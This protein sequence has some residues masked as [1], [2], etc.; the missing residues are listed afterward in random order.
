MMRNTSHKLIACLTLL[1]AGLTAQNQGGQPG[2]PG[3]AQPA[4][5]Q[6]AGAQP[7]P[8]QAGPAPAGAPATASNPA[9]A[10]PKTV[11]GPVAPFRRSQRGYLMDLTAIQGVEPNTITGIGLVTGLMTGN[12]DSS[13]ISR[14]AV[15]DF[16]RRNGKNLTIS[17]TSSNTYALVAISAVIPP[18]AKAGQFVD[19]H[20]SVMGDAKSLFGG[21]L[22]SAKLNGPDGQTYALASGK[23]IANGRFDSGKNAEVNEGVPTN[24]T[25]VRGAKLN[26]N[27]PKSYYLDDKGEL[28]LRLLHPSIISVQS[29]VE[30]INKRVG[31]LGYEARVVDEALLKVSLPENK[32]TEAGAMDL[33]P[34]IQ[35]VMIERVGKAIIQIDQGTGTVIIGEGV[36]ILPCA[37]T[38]GTV[39]ITIIDDSHISQPEP[40]SLGET[41][42]FN[43]TDIVKTS[44]VKDFQVYQ[45]AGTLTDLVKYFKMLGAKPKDVINVFSKLHQA[46]FLIAELK[47]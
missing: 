31:S 37:I 10:Q 46:G 27:V 5:T 28:G 35:T 6:P 14:R 3:P 33:L 19:V 21:F 18:F 30:G 20:V 12:G 9:P 44:E 45:G 7:G 11:S 15:M 13:A 32:R 36:Q 4:G 8:N 22:Q 25:V 47:H 34:L 29:A 39:E 38:V 41:T 16:I 24:A 17:D 1:C 40:F 23:L 43:R 42:E 2:Q 26:A